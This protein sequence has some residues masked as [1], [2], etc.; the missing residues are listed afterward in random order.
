MPA[1]AAIDAA[2]GRIV[3][4]AS[5]A[6]HRQRGEC[7]GLAEKTHLAGG[8][9]WTSFTLDPAS[10]ALYVPAGNPAPDFVGSYRPGANLYS[11]SVVVLDAKT[12]SLRTW[13][14]LVPHDVH[15]WDIAAAPVLLTTTQGQRRVVAA[16]KDGFMHT[17]DPLPPARV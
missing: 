10:G 1:M 12:G 6:S 4:S 15:D 16:G 11:G 5:S 17:V 9:T 13:Y 3:W 14:Q 8:S 2:T 7:R